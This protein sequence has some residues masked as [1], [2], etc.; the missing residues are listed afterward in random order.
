MQPVEYRAFAADLVNFLDFV[1]E[2]TKN[3]RISLGIAV[4]MYLIVLF[5][6][7]YALKRLYWKNVPH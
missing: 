5:G 6:L 4:L 1:G 3:K 7:V 2:P